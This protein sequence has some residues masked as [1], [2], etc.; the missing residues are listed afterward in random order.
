MESTSADVAELT[1]ELEVE[2]DLHP[3]PELVQV[4]ASR[5]RIYTQSSDPTVQGLYDDF[6][7]GYLI[8][9]PDLQRYFVWDRAKSSRLIE[10][11]LLNVPLPV[12]YLAQESD[13]RASVIDGQQRLTA[14]FQYIDGDFALHGLH[15]LKE[16]DGL[17]F[18]D[19]DR[20][21]QRT[22]Q[23]CSIRT[24][25]VLKESDPESRFEIF[26]RLNTGSVALND[27]ELRNCVYRGPY[28]DLIKDLARDPD[29]MYLLGIKEP[30]RRKRDVELVLRFSAFFH[31][32]YLEL[33]ASDAPFLIVIWN[34]I[35]KSV[36]TAL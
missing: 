26:E 17:R 6:K 24:I 16:I 35:E 7:T 27:Q 14:F 19:L 20:S 21:Q 18:Q 29:Y 5:R 10:S 8:L 4:D 15:V 12:V 9:Q 28:N 36:L 2:E 33:S 22:I 34:S 30:E 32:T 25:T 1:D 11:V 23:Q 3:E 31:S 13:G